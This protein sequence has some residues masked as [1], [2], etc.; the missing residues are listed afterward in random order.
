MVERENN[1]RTHEPSLR[2][3][4]AE[5]DGFRQLM[6]ER[7]RRYG[8]RFD[9][10]EKAVSAALAAQEKLGA[11]VNMASE[12]AI[13]KAEDAQNQYNV[14]SNEFRGA[15]DDAQKVLLPRAEADQ[16]FKA[17]EEKIDEVKENFQIVQNF[18]AKYGGA[19]ESKREDRTQGQWVV[20][21]IIGVCL[22]AAQIILR[23]SGH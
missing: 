2:E 22:A 14:R 15:L 12:K 11:T 23:L 5:L 21:I 19:T 8:E 16:R 17:I 3:V 7:D 18:I 13:A 20:G 4:V 10:Q 6:D 1:G 9:A